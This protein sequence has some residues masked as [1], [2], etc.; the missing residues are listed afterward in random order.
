MFQKQ[1]DN[2]TSSGQRTRTVPSMKYVTILQ[3]AV[4]VHFIRSHNGTGPART[5]AQLRSHSNTYLC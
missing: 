5:C 3:F 2:I 1:F 4:L